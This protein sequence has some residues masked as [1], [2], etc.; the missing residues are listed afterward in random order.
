MNVLKLIIMETSKT[1]E[2]LNDLVQINNDRIKG[3]ETALE[4]LK[5]ED[6]DLRPLFL[7]LIDESRQL[8]IAL[9]HEVQVLGGSID[10]STRLS[11]KIYRAWMSV[12]AV[13]T[14]HDRH[15]V[16]SNCEKGEDAAQQAYRDAL[17]EE[18]LPSYIRELI[19]QQKAELR[20]SHDEIKSFRNHATV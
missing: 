17:S 3:Y 2:I 15:T 16:L 14:G 13:F 7:N 4:E 10:D 1:I 12:A 8:K 20:G 9:G 5:P 11:G 6:A 19:T 18:E